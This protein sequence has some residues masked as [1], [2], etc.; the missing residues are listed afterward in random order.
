[1]YTIL[2]A[3]NGID[4]TDWIWLGI[5][6]LFDIVQPGWQLRAARAGRV[7]LQRR[8]AGDLTSFTGG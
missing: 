7:E 1:M 2:Y 8:S 3:P 4:G 6:A 5:A